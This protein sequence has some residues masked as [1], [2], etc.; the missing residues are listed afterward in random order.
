MSAH[1]K[2][3]AI[4]AIRVLAKQ[5]SR[6]FTHRAVDRQA[7]LPEGTASRYARTR[8][9]L[10]ALAADQLFTDDR[11]TSAQALH[12]KGGAEEQF[13]S[14]IPAIASAL[15]RVTTAM[16]R[17]RDHYRARLELQLESA[18]DTALRRRF[19]QG[20]AA[21]AGDLASMLD[22][23]SVPD[24]KIRADELVMMLDS[25]LHRQLVLAAPPLSETELR[26]L[27]IAIIDDQS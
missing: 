15:V 9:A 14:D 12:N 6:G 27:F 8:A 21:F 26:R 1:H 18:R 19:L 23:Q 7:K 22:A 11:W 4:A 2:P 25:V 24:S 10:L 17:T 20:R 5:G 13:L 16:L 3:L